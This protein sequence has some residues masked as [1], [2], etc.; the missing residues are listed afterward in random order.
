MNLAENIIALARQ[1]K[2]QLGLA[3]SCTGGMIASALTDI[4]GASAVFGLGLVTYANAAKQR[5]LSV[6]EAMIMEHGA[7]SE[8]VAAAMVMGLLVANPAIDLGLAV[9]GIAGPDG[10]STDKPVGLVYFG[11][12]LRGNAA[13]IEKRI[14]TG[15][16]AAIRAAARDY[17]LG[18]LHTELQS[19]KF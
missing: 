7:V 10:G 2:I 3:E 18:L 14:F 9:T 19:D 11:W 17:G 4:P 6:P 5:Y 16:R 15:N 13:M 8:Q 12:Q 1:R